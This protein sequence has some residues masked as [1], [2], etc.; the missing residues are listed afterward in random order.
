VG[1]IHPKITSKPDD[2]IEDYA[3]QLKSQLEV[4]WQRN[5]TKEKF[6]ELEEL[7]EMEFLIFFHYFYFLF[8]WR[9]FLD[10]Y[11]SVQDSDLGKL[12]HFIFCS[13]YSTWNS[14]NPRSTNFLKKS[15]KRR[16]KVLVFGF[17]KFRFHDDLYMKKVNH[18]PLSCALYSAQNKKRVKSMS[19]TYFSKTRM[20][21]YGLIRIVFINRVLS[22]FITCLSGTIVW[23][24]YVMGNGWQYRILRKFYVGWYLTTFPKKIQSFRLVS[25]ILK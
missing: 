2:I 12:F 23:N 22:L 17:R 13:S 16:T 3:N 5:R 21:S 1:R 14:W 25:Q 6:V 7:M 4:Y 10:W 19:K 20:N 8:K 18:S 11:F 24:W 15:F 9:G